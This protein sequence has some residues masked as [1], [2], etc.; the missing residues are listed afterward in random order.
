MGIIGNGGL[1][2]TDILGVQ[3][4]CAEHA[5]L[6]HGRLD[7]ELL[8][9][10]SHGSLEPLDGVFRRAIGALCLYPITP[11]PE[12][13]FRISLP[14]R[15]HSRRTTIAH[16]QDGGQRRVHDLQLGNHHGHIGFEGRMLSSNSQIRPHCEVSGQ[17]SS[18]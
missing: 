17:A 5:R 4:I 12:L 3:Q 1:G 14:F 13:T 2:V 18:S 8:D 6:D 15:N 9:L 16:C 7:P 10:R 11:P